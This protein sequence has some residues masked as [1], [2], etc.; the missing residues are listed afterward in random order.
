MRD[1]ISGGVSRM[2]VAKEVLRDV[3]GSLED[4]PGLYIAL[5][6]Y[7]SRVIDEYACRDS[8]LFQPFGSVGEVRE[9]ILR[10]VDALQ[11]RGRTPIGLSLQLAADDFPMNP[12]DRNIIVLIT[13]GQESCGIDPCAV[14]YE[15]QEKGII[16]KPYVVG[17]AMSA[18]EEATVRCIGEYYSAND[19]DSL[20]E[21]LQSILVKVIAPRPL[22][23]RP[24]AVDRVSLT[25]RV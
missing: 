6:V 1:Q 13:D 4:Q 24:M 10:V 9:N 23:S 18:K 12:G 15:L 19:R 22:R 11:P 2:A 25:G 16:M 17:F 7:G 14:S 3:I 5:R 20:T 8:E 21:A